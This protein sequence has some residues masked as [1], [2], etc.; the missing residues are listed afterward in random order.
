M[1]VS[2]LVIEILHTW[3]EQYQPQRVLIFPVFHIDLEACISFN[4]SKIYQFIGKDPRSVYSTYDTLCAMKTLG[5]EGS[6]LKG[7]H[8]TALD[9]SFLI[10]NSTGIVVSG[11]T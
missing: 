10:L 6:P 7:G 11:T 2:K 5:L 9:A 4:I 8:T 3:T 1:V